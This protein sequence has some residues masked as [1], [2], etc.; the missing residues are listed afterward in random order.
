MQVREVMRRCL[1]DDP[2]GWQELWLLVETAALTPIRA[3]LERHGVDLRLA[4][5]AIQELYFH[6]KDRDGRL[7]EAFAG[8]TEAELRGYLAAL[9]KT[10]ARDYVRALRRAQLREEKA[11]KR[12]HV[13][14]LAHPNIGDL[15][16]TLGEFQAQL[17]PAHLARLQ[18]LLELAGVTDDKGAAGAEPAIP[19]RR[20]RRWQ[21]ELHRRFV[22]WCQQEQSK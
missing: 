7:M 5:D 18:R 22:A 2:E 1:A 19:P 21:R 10:F 14:T 3:I 16:A 6:L 20:I 8:T 17:P 15:L 12:T 4:E 9:A 11:L 13:A